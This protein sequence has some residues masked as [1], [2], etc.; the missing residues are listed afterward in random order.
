MKHTFVLRY[1]VAASLLSLAGCQCGPTTCSTND[2]CSGG[3]ICIEGE[4]KPGSVDGGGAGGGTGGGETDGGTGGGAQG[5]GLGGGTGGGGGGAQ[6]G[7]SG[8]G[9]QSHVCGD[10]VRGGA[11]V[12]DDRNTTSGDGCSATCTLE[13]G[14]VCPT[15]GVACVAERCGDGFIAGLEECDDGN[16][17]SGDGCSSGCTIEEGYACNDAGVGCV[18][19]DCGNG[20]REGI[21][22]CDDGN[23]DLGDG[24]DT[25]C[26]A[27]PRCS[28]GV[29]TAVCGDGIR[30]AGEMCDDGNTRA[31]D[32]CSP[33]CTQEPGFTCVDQTPAAQQRLAIPIVYRDFLP[34]GADGGHIDFENK[35]T[36]DQGIVGLFL[37]DAGKPVY[38]SA[39][40]TP[41]TH[42]AQFF[43]QWYRDT[44]NVNRTETDRLEVVRQ[45]NGSYVFDS[46]DFFPL[47]NR[48]WARD[49]TE[50]HRHGHNFNFT[51]ELRYWFNYAGGES[52]DFRGDDDVWV[53]ING[54]RAVDL[55]GVHGPESGGIT[56]DANAAT[57][58]N[59]RDGGVYEAVVFQ[60][61][62][63]TTGSSYRLTLRGFNA[64]RSSCDWRCG[65]GIVTRFEA[66][67]DGVNDGRYGGCMPGCQSR[68]G[69]CGDS[70][71]QPDAGE[72]CDD[73]NNSGGLCGPGCRRVGCG[74]GVTQVDAG[75]QCDDGNTV[76]GD[77]CSSTCIFEI[78]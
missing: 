62:R 69:F 21:E 3:N 74:D 17:T 38:A 61:E 32:G 22:Q 35:N 5:G 44:P 56:L 47:D 77:G 18:T 12:C 31:G 72:E 6:G 33:Q 40:T 20:I 28:D 14:W 48:G 37:G 75:E 26:K 9:G 2:E 59:L 66:C 49:G 8:G 67:D 54:R 71:H 24:C 68:A 63:H 34:W 55:G 73:G 1:V 64:P 23:N 11:E 25:T 27:E 13:A 50:P 78:G 53:F 57:T 76:S 43:N 45:S 51:S 46:N 39:T 30:Q 15:V 29:C 70:V 4:C 58:F 42:G 7:G 19:T 41:S 60:A 10:G 36:G 65:D 16:T 52:L